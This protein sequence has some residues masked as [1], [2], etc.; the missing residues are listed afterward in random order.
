MFVGGG[1]RCVCI[2][3][4]R[5]VGLFGQREANRNFV[6]GLFDIVH[7][8]VL[9]AVGLLVLDCILEMGQRPALMTMPDGATASGTMNRIVGGLQK[10]RLIR[11]T[12]RIGRNLLQI[13][14]RILETLEV[15]ASRRHTGGD[16]SGQARSEHKDDHAACMGS[17]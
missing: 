8:F 1:L 15:V 12:V 17:A 5:V 13:V 3:C 9:C 6:Q 2:A 7:Q 11:S 16:K 10:F 4:I 14:L